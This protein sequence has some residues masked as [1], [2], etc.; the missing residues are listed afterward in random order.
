MEDI[1]DFAISNHVRKFIR[2]EWRYYSNKL[3]NE[4]RQLQNAQIGCSVWHLLLYE[5]KNFVFIFTTLERHFVM[6]GVDNK[7]SQ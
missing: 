3:A 7:W 1:N 2:S 4:L 5:F 6:I